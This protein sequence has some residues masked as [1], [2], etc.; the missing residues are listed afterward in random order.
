MGIKERRK[1]EK[2]L[3]REKIFDAARELFSVEGYE[4][5][6]IRRLAE[7]I[8]YSPTA[9]YVHFTDKED[10]FRQLCHADFAKITELLRETAQISDPVQRLV[11]CSKLYA[12]F[13]MQFPNHYKLMF[14]TV[15]DYALDD[16]DRII[17]GNPEKDAYAFLY[18]S[19][20]NLMP[21]GIFRDEIADPHLIMQTMWAGIH[22]V[23]S[24]NIAKGNNAWVEWRPF[25]L[26]IEL[27]MDSI[28]RGMM[29]IPINRLPS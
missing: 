8:E 1:R 17:K 29:K 7:K 5:V 3:T 6:S 9:I 28:L 13:A 19:V 11:E 16:S 27:M 21:L 23:I 14:M 2:L 18:E 4:S 12:G 24:L 25:S 10:L 22:G 20:A 15:H 26:R